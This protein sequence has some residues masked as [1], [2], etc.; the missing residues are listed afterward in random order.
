M[1]WAHL[2]GKA[3]PKV[4]R[5]RLHDVFTLGREWKTMEELLFT[6]TAEHPSLTAGQSDVR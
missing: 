4:I 5:E 2:E 6:A 1:K 3:P